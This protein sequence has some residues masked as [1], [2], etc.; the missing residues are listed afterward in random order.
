MD[1]V[2]EQS[3]LNNHTIHKYRFKVLG[4]HKIDE[5]TTKEDYGQEVFKEKKIITKQENNNENKF[6]EELL[7]KS[8]DLSTNIIKLQM[9]IE[10]QESEFENRLKDTV[11][12]EKEISF[13]EG[14][15]KAKDELEANYN[16]KISIYIDSTKKLNEKTQEI[17]DFF[18]KLEKNLLDTSLEVAKEV[19]K[20]EIKTSSSQVAVAL[21]KELMNDLKDVNKIT[22]KVNPKE[23]IKN[24]DRINETITM[25]KPGSRLAKQAAKMYLRNKKMRMFVN[26][27]AAGAIG[28]KI[29]DGGFNLD[30]LNK[31][32]DQYK[33][34]DQKK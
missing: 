2:I 22:L 14:Y 32:L 1:N 4:S 19:I 30:N 23:V 17:D 7:K 16:E 15:A 27:A 33:N 21:A 3:E 24:L 13:N 28:K 18:K 26:F 31:V 8:D 29:Y 20:K 11:S 34:N 12:R 9:Q 10:K 6:I 5:E 25:F